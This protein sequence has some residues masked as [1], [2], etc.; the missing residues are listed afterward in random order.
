MFCNFFGCSV[1]NNF[2]AFISTF[3][4]HSQ[5]ELGNAIRSK[6][7][8]CNQVCPQVQLENK[9]A[10]YNFSVKC[11]PKFNLGTQDNKTPPILSFLQKAFG[12]LGNGLLQ[13]V[14]LCHIFNSSN[15]IIS[16]PSQSLLQ[17]EL[18]FQHSGLFTSPFFTGL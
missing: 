16:F 7:K 15:L 10:K 2:S 12:T 14:S 17:S 8:L 3:F 11:V 18:Y 13:K 5:V 9:K 4:P 1:G 6:V